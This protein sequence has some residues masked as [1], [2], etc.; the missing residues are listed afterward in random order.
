MDPAKAKEARE[1]M[2]AADAAVATSLFKWKADWLAAE[3]LYQKA[4]RAFKSAGL[5][6][7]AIAAWK[8]AV[9][10]SIKMGN[11]KQAVV[12]LEATARELITAAGSAS[13]ATPGSYKAQAS[14]ML[15]EAGTHLIEGGE[16][17]RGADMKLRAGKLLE[18]VD[19]DRA[20]KLYDEACNIFDGDEDKDVYA[21]EALTK[22]LTH[23]L[24]LSK[25]ASAMR[26]MDK[27]AKIFTRL[28]QSHNTYKLVLSRVVLLL[29]AGDTVAA[30]GEY[31]KF[32]DIPGFAESTE[33][34]AAEDLIEAMGGAWWP[35]RLC[36]RAR[37]SRVHVRMPPHRRS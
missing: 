3:P 26:T 31:H 28:N 21:K 30:T 13:T 2:E 16:I 19:N 32:L 7:S 17:A 11:V 5:M 1:A 35:R 22:V 36:A 24:G 8:Q 6:D 34:A 23:Q 18:G 9:V 12:T 20:A 27:L 14:A 33:A 25:H 10:C 15:S 4:G 37:S 29:G